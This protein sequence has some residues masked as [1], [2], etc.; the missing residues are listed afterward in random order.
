M[1]LSE[2]PGAPTCQ[3]QGV[4]AKD[5]WDFEL[6]EACLR[7]ARTRERVARELQGLEAEFG[8]RL[9]GVLREVPAASADF[10]TGQFVWPRGSPGTLGDVIAHHRQV[11]SSR[12]QSSGEPPSTRTA[13]LRRRGKDAACDN[14]RLLYCQ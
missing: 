1:P 3:G 6:Y 8:V 13:T 7:C 10:Q 14:P 12:R 11:T 4:V 2:L 9:D 5:N